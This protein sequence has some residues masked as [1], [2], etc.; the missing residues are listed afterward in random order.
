[1]AVGVLMLARWPSE[2][3]F[4]AITG[5]V[6][7]LLIA[8]VVP[9]FWQLPFVAKV[10]FPWRLMIVVEFAAITAL[11]GAP[12]PARL[13]LARVVFAA[14]VAALVPGLVSMTEGIVVRA[15][16]ARAGQTEPAADLKQFL[17]AG[18][19]QKPD[20]GYAELSGHSP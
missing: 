7:L 16:L 3:A 9:W 20:G 12:W 18:Y 15:Q 10:Q 1:M 17:P 8:G 19:P 6:C 2:A 13:R 4:W 5:L 11:A 14:A